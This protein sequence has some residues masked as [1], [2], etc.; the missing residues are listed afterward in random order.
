[1]SVVAA[2]NFLGVLA[3]D[4]RKQRILGVTEWRRL[5]RRTSLVPFAAVAAGGSRSSSH[6]KS[7]LRL[8]AAVGL[9]VALLTLHQHV[10]GVSPFPP[11]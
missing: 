8:G 2:L 6:K 9:Y 11:L 5:S 1:M 10:F 4:S 7:L 3:I